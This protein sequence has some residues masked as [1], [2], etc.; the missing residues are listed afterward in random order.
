MASLSAA[1]RP[2]TCACLCALPLVRRQ[3]LAIRIL[4]L[5]HVENGPDFVC[6][7]H[8]SGVVFAPSLKSGSR[9]YFSAVSHLFTMAV[10]SYHLLEEPSNTVLKRSLEALLAKDAVP[11]KA[12]TPADKALV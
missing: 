1:A 5:E 7:D 2:P 4:E 8:P 3:F 12:A 9:L 10:I 6:A 11:H